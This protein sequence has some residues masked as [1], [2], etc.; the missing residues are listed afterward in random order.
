MTN[1][2]APRPDAEVT[3]ANCEACCCRQE[4]MLFNDIEVPDHLTEVNPRGGKSMAR[5]EDGWCK[6]LD[7]E[8]MLC[9]IYERRPW[10]WRE[11]E[12]GEYECLAARADHL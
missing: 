5:L 10:I 3:C 6:A 7:R 8:T 1:E 2:M 11:F 4:A 12:V 9:T